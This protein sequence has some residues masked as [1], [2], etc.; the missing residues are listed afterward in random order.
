MLRA[1]F[2]LSLVVQSCQVW[3]AVNRSDEFGIGV[4][5][6][7]P[8]AIV[9]KYYED[10]ERAFDGGIGYWFGD[11]LDIYGDFLWHWPDAL[12]KRRHPAPQ[13][14][15]YIGGGLG[16]HIASSSRTTYD[17]NH[18]SFGIYIRIPLG[19]EWLPPKAPFG[20]FVELVPTIQLIPGLIGG[21]GG[22]LGGRFYF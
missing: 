14:V 8:T 11:Y 7:A 6:G 2:V 5:I 4:A 3:G 10:P 13:F 16:F 20:V 1:L 19:V 15:P 12:S 9:G 18:P 22:V 17:N 21:F